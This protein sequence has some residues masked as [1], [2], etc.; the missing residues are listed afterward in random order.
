[1]RTEN[2]VRALLKEFKQ[3]IKIPKGIKC[4]LAG[5]S[6][7]TLFK[8]EYDFNIKDW[9]IFVET[10]QDYIRLVTHFDFFMNRRIETDNA[11]SFASQKN[12]G[13]S[14]R[15]IQ[16]IKK[17]MGKTQQVINDFD[18]AICAVAYE[19]HTDTFKY[20]KHW[21]SDMKYNRLRLGDTP[22]L[23]LSFYRIEKYE[24]KGFLPIFDK[25]KVC[26]RCLN[27]LSCLTV[28]DKRCLFPK[29]S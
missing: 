7:I 4:C 13:F 1:M 6:L 17:R 20:H 8:G 19:F 22:I 29:E 12:F 9:D 15:I 16:V 25:G 18:L 28:G 11:V 14:S 5:G 26:E 10:E 24:M 21:H 23:D 2:E 3:T 27:R